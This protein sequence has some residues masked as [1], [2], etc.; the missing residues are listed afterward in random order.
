MRDM[1]APQAYAVGLTDTEMD[2]IA[3]AVDRLDRSDGQRTAEGDIRRMAMLGA[4]CVLDATEVTN[5]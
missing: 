3:R 4:A 5:G 1:D 2:V